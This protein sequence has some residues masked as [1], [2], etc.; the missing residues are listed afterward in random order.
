MDRP[1]VPLHREALLPAIVDA[2]NSVRLFAWFA[3]TSLAKTRQTP[4]AQL[5]SPA[6]MNSPALS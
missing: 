4:C 6:Y 2:V 5:A 3:E 1:C